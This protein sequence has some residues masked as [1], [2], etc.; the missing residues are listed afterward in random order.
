MQLRQLPVR[1]RGRGRGRPHPALRR[2]QAQALPDRGGLL[3]LVLLR[4]RRDAPGGH[5]EIIILTFHNH[6]STGGSR[7]QADRVRGPGVCKYLCI[8]YISIMSSWSPAPV[9]VRPRP[10]LPEEP[11]LRSRAVRAH[12]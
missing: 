11:G 7:V 9:H 12:A 4:L 2:G 6:H 1:L 8:L 3:R 5:H 10:H